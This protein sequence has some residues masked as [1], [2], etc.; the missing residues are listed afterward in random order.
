[1]VR[2]YWLRGWP[3]GRGGDGGSSESSASGSCSGGLDREDGVIASARPSPSHEQGVVLFAC[4]A[5]L[6]MMVPASGSGASRARSGELRPPC[7]LRRWVLG[8]DLIPGAWGDGGEQVHLPVPPGFS[9]PCAPCRRPRRPGAR[10]RARDPRR[11]RGPATDAAGAA[12]TSRPPLPPGTPPRPAA[13]ASSSSAF[14]P[15]RAAAAR[16]ARHTRPGQRDPAQGRPR[17]PSGQPRTRRRSS[18]RRQPVRSI[19]A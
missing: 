14:P 2:V 1:M 9:R 13:S 15:A 19:D 18:S 12:G 10:E 11:Q 8:D 16:G 3:A 6:V 4:M 5:S 17:P 7:L